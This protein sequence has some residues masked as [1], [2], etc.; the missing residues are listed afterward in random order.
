MTTKRDYYEILSVSRTAGDDEIKKSYR[1]L[2]KKYHPDLNPNNAEAEERFKE[3]AEAYEV[4][5]DPEKRRV[6]DNYGHAG[7]EGRGFHGFSDVSDVFSSFS[8]LFDS[9]FGFSRGQQRRD[10]PRAGDDLETAIRIPFREAVF[11][12]R[13]EVQIERE[14]DCAAC[15][16]KGV[17]PGSSVETCPTC[18]GRGQVAHTRGFFSIASACP[19]C[20]GTGRFVRNPCKDC[21]GAGRRMERKKIEVEIPAGVDHGMRVRLAGEGDA[22]HRGGPRGDLY[23]VLAVEPDRRFRREGDHVFT[24]ISVGPA[25]AALGAKL[26]IETLDGDEEVEIEPGIQSGDTVTLEGKGIPRLRRGGRGNHLVEVEVV[27]PR[28][29]SKRQEELLREFA[30]E[31]GESVLPPKEGILHKLRKKKS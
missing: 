13:R 22:G 26:K 18:G 25:Q 6:Y 11:G 30:Q 21:H 31:A 14:A 17:S 19:Q 4:L 16:G 5:R 7:L 1:A 28:R 29:L 8:D 2:A 27:T 3:A 10:G 12:C 15:G 9:F 20:R 23:V 24:R